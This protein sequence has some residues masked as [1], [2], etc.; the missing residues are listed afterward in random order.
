MSETQR[1]GIEPRPPLDGIGS[2]LDRSLSLILARFH[3]QLGTIHTLGAD[4]LL[5]LCAH[6]P[7]IPEPVLAA[8]RVIPIGK[9]MAGLAVERRA[10]IN[11]CNLQQDKSGDV[12]PGAQATGAMGS[13]CV[14]LL[15]GDKAVGALGIA[16]LGERTFTDAEVRE[17]LDIGKALAACLATQPV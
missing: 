4:G 9:G 17:L 16:S 12:R 7:G 6:S 1:S 10:P 14:P 2:D 15:E 13:L 11:V 3:A 8:T 5:H